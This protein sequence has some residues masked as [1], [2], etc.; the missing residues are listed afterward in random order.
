MNVPLKKKKV[1]Y[2]YSLNMG[3]KLYLFIGL[4]TFF[5][6]HIVVY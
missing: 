2:A 4:R 5:L 3:R 6:L 1:S